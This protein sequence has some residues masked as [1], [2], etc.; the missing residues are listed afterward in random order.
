M[1]DLLRNYGV[2]GV[3]IGMFLLGLLLRIIY[4]TFVED[5]P[6]VL[7]RAT[8]YFMLLMAVNYETFFAAI[9][10]YLFKIG[11]TA[12]VGVVIVNLLAR[13][14]NPGLDDAR[15]HASYCDSMFPVQ[16]DK[17]W[18]TIGERM[19]YFGVIPADEFGPDALDSNAK[20]TF[21][22][23]G[24]EHVSLVFDWARRYFTEASSLP[25]AS[26]LGAASAALS[27]RSQG[28]SRLSWASI[29]PEE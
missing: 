23:S 13:R 15:A 27:F 9:I 5:Q 12:V 18:K 4:R 25:G 29:Y 2:I 11:T 28:G 8:L 22:V 26:I 3:P 24:E 19:P 1:G 14:L 20:D 7:W 21:F 6:A 10:P 17:S 16:T